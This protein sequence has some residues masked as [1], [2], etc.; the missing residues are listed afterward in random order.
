MSFTLHPIPN[1][2]ICRS[3]IGGNLKVKPTCPVHGDKAQQ[4]DDLREVR[5]MVMLVAI[6]LAIGTGV[7][8]GMFIG[9]YFWH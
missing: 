1:G 4:Q 9:R 8:A 5:P 2:C 6:F 7:I 3:Y